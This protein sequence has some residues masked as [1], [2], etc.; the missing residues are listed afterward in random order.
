MYYHFFLSAV[1]TI[2]KI[3]SRSIDNK[4]A[5]IRRI[6]SEY[7]RRVA[8]KLN[9]LT[10]DVTKITYADAIDIQNKL[11]D[12]LSD[13]N[14]DDVPADIKRKLVELHISHKRAKEEVS[15]CKADMFNTMRYLTNERSK[16]ITAMKHYQSLP[17]CDYTRGAISILC[18]QKTKLEKLFLLYRDLFLWTSA[19]SEEELE[20]Y[21]LP[22][23]QDLGTPVVRNLPEVDVFSDGEDKSY[24]QESLSDAESEALDSGFSFFLE[25]DSD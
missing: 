7:N 15:L 8:F 10:E 20:P 17:L 25:E 14:S 24:H 6:L 3:L 5:N 1:Q 16:A 9:V 23:V 18:Q 4:V 22:E 13:F 21:S 2:S 11:Y 12:N 19:I